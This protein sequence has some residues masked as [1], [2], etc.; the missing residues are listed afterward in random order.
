MSS[1][2]RGLTSLHT[3]WY[4]LLDTSHTLGYTTVRHLS[5]PEVR[6]VYACFILFPR[7]FREVLPVIPS[8]SLGVLGK[9]CLLFLLSLGVLGRFLPVILFFLGVLG[10]FC[11]L[12]SLF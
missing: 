3:L 12:F 4:T 7:G 9:F 11:L 8:F 6:E 1:P 10:R 2:R 5:H